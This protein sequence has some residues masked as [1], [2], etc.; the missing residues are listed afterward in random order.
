MTEEYSQ[1]ARPVHVPVEIDGRTL[2]V[3]VVP[4]GEQEDQEVAACRLPR[5]R[6]L[7]QSS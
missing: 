7:A 1:S 6:A 2:F 5:A 4:V 3:E